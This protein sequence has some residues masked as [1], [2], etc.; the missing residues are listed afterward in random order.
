MNPYR[1][2]NIILAGVLIVIFSYSGFFVSYFSKYG[3]SCAFR[4]QTGLDCATC[5]FTRDF[6]IFL[7]KGDFGNPFNQFSSSVFVFLVIQFF[8]RF[9]IMILNLDIKFKQ[10]YLVDAIFSVVYFL[11]VFVPI[12]LLSISQSISLLS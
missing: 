8:L 12:L 3:V 2:I 5:G 10:L 1:I 9:G 11:N 4:S 6:N 7:T